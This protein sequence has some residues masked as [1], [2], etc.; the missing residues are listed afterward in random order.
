MDLKPPKFD[1]TPSTIELQKFIY[2]YENIVTI[3]GLKET[4]GIEFTTFLFSG[5]PE[6][7][8]TSILRGRQAGL[9][10]IT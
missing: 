9:P 7:W 8:W 1:A 5:S 6:A 4:R 2:C 10:P 3:L